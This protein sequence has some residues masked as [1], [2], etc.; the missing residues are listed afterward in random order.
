MA[1]H[2]LEHLLMA[3]VM[4][5]GVSVQ[6]VPWGCM[7]CY[8]ATPPPEAFSLSFF[9][10]TPRHAWPC[11]S[12]NCGRHTLGQPMA[13]LGIAGSVPVCPVSHVLHQAY[14]VRFAQLGSCNTTVA[15]VNAFHRPAIR[16][17]CLPVTAPTPGSIF[18]NEEM[19]QSCLPPSFYTA[20]LG[21]VTTRP[22]PVGLCCVSYCPNQWLSR[23]SS[24]QH[25]NC[26]LSCLFLSHLTASPCL[27]LGKVTHAGWLAP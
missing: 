13:C 14:Q 20:C 15:A 23:L 11:L 18:F 8:K 7:S 21:W 12:G 25:W 22:P 1:C 4:P 16:P 27:V 2:R 19:P 17:S 5:W 3:V 6:P 26:C 10:S 24:E 9:F